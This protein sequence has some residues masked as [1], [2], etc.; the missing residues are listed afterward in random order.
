MQES[1]SAAKARSRD[2]AVLDLFSKE[3]APAKIEP[4][5]SHMHDSSQTYS[6]ISPT[7]NLWGDRVELSTRHSH[8][9]HLTP[10][11]FD[12]L[13][14]LDGHREEESDEF[15]LNVQLNKVRGLLTFY[16][17]DK[18]IYCDKKEGTTTW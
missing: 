3:F 4:A 18:R 6:R 17:V 15:L 12:L 13:K 9:E 7:A 5:V 10:D 1:R 14:S 11:R 8:S 16:F 2:A